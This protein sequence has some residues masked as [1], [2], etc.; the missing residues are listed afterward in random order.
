ML[1]CTDGVKEEM[2]L[3]KQYEGCTVALYREKNI[4][5]PMS[6]FENNAVS[7]GLVLRLRL[8]AVKD[9]LHKMLGKLSL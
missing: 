8:V 7:L 2:K 5:L 1:L 9:D 3:S 6:V 4:P